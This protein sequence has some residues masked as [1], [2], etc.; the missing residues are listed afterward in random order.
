MLQVPA[1]R[2]SFTQKLFEVK[3]LLKSPR[4]KT[5]GVITRSVRNL[6][7]SRAYGRHKLFRLRYTFPKSSNLRELTTRDGLSFSPVNAILNSM[8][9]IKL[10][11]DQN[12][13]TRRVGKRNLNEKEKK[14]RITQFRCY[15]LA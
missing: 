1:K 4:R 5:A 2:F 7:T 13:Q 10:D 8:Y 6:P 14:R 15:K 3:S 9:T 11:G 12:S